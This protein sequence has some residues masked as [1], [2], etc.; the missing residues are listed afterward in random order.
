MILEIF[1]IYTE[2]VSKYAIQEACLYAIPKLKF[3][4]DN[5]NHFS[6]TGGTT[7]YTGRV[8]QGPTANRSKSLCLVFFFIHSA[9]PI[10]KLIKFLTASICTR[11]GKLKAWPGN[12]L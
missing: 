2:C 4:V 8:K 10:K 3:F 11:E 12:L 9:S 6:Y 5:K 1:G 7:D